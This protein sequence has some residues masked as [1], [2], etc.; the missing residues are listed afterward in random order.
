MQAAR[1]SNTQGCADRPQ[2]EARTAATAQLTSSHTTWTLQFSGGAMD[3]VP[4][5]VHPGIAG[6]GCAA[7]TPHPDVVT[8]DSPPRPATAGR[9]LPP[10]TP[11]PPHSARGCGSCSAWLTRRAHCTA[12]PITRDGQGLSHPLPLALHC[13]SG[14]AWEAIYRRRITPYEQ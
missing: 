13:T 11:A 5:T 14:A 3:L 2:G 6:L 10:G 1:H 4:L 9:A 7:S 8:V 12:S